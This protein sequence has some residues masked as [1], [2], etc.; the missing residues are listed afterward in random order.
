MEERQ[1]LSG[2]ISG[3]VRNGCGS[4][5]GRN[6]PLILGELVSVAE[7]MEALKR[8]RTFVQNRYN[9]GS[10]N[11]WKDPTTK[12]VWIL[13]D[14][15]DLVIGVDG[16]RRASGVGGQSHPLGPVAGTGTLVS[17]K[18]EQRGE[19]L[20]AAELAQ[21]DLDAIGGWE[22]PKAEETA[23][24]V[25]SGKNNLS[26]KETVQSK[27]KKEARNENHESNGRLHGV[28]QPD[29]VNHVG[30]LGHGGPEQRRS[31][32]EYRPS[33]NLGHGQ[34]RTDAH[35]VKWR[36][37]EL[38]DELCLSVEAWR[39]GHPRSVCERD[40]ARRQRPLHL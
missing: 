33:H 40:C 22:A 29:R 5:C 7:A 18:R 21:E 28:T 14:D 37:D 13:K 39:G 20:T 35:G 1:C 6:R 24:I 36:L 16:R 11:Y 8:S 26:G 15:L 27:P 3:G 25:S 10:L 38:P 31:A 12:R 4:C 2:G 30:R 9:E 32:R 34:G 19:E 23:A 17:E